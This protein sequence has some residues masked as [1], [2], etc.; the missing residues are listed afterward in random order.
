MLKKLKVKKG[1]LGARGYYIT[2]TLFFVYK[3]KV[4]SSRPSPR[5]TCDKRPLVRESDSGW[6]HRHTMM[7]VIKIY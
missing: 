3:G 6:C 5:E 1:A 4:K 7:S 2:G